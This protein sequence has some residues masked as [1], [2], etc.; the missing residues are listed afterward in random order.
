MEV[1]IFLNAA[2]LYHDY[3]GRSFRDL[4]GNGND[5]IPTANCYF[6]PK[7]VR[8]GSV[9]DEISVSDSPEL[10][11][12]EGTLVVFGDFLS[13]VTNEALISKRDGGGT[14]YQF[15]VQATTLTLFNGTVS[16]TLT[17]NIKD[18]KYVAVNFEHN[19]QPVGY[20]DGV[21][22]GTFSAS[23]A[24][25][26]D[27]APVVIGNILNGAKLRSNL[28]GALI[29]PRKLTATEHAQLYS[30]L[31][32]VNF[33]Q[34]TDAPAPLRA[35]VVQVDDLVVGYDM[36]TA[37]NELTDV[38]KENDNG[39]ISKLSQGQDIGRHLVNYG[40]GVVNFTGTPV[41]EAFTMNI[42]FKPDDITS[43]DTMVGH[44]SGAQKFGV[45][46]SNLFLRLINGGSSDTSVAAAPSG[47]L[48]SVVITRDASNKVDLYLN[49]GSANRLF[50]DVAQSGSITFNRLFDDNALAQSFLGKIYKFEIFNTAKNATWVQEDFKR[51][52]QATWETYSGVYES[53]ANR[54]E[55]LENSPFRIGSGSFK[56][57]SELI[58]G[59]IVKSI[60]CI[61]DGYLYM[62]TSQMLQTLSEA[63]NGSFEWHQVKP[64]TKEMSV[65]FGNSQNINSA[66]SY[67]VTSDA[68]EVL[69]LRESGVGII[70]TAGTAI[71][72]DTLERLKL[73]VKDGGQF[74]LYLGGV[75]QGTVTD[76]TTQT[77]KYFGLNM[78]V[79]CKV[80][81]SDRNNFYSIKKKLLA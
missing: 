49:G 26:V 14:N 69:T 38:S 53:V 71:T 67:R 58:D 29:F 80:A 62:P 25:T 43:S 55:I 64:D 65:G 1:P 48:S 75:S 56:I 8:I 44:N 63:A 39:S 9:T 21:E 57:T 52:Q 17:A 73:T 54:S 13:Q 34:I 60:E 41:S 30:Y 22:A 68:S 12:T 76:T 72:P 61:T 66:P 18:K 81:Y 20:I 7:G 24:I 2:V 31:S 15:I 70:L 27:D 40:G 6:T 16:S 35:D 3:R 59:Q 32:N 78:Q 11:L 33:C 42:W 46:S 5:G 23:I 4:S 47:R 10:Q 50:G 45:A 37:A 79:G 36:Q 19:T 28:I 77:A 51:L 74:E